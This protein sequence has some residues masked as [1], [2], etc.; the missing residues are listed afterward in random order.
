[1]AVNAEVQGLV[2][3]G[4]L[5]PMVDKGHVFGHHQRVHQ[6]EGILPGLGHALEDFMSL[7]TMWRFL[8][9]YR[10]ELLEPGECPGDGPACSRSWRRSA[11]GC[12]GGMR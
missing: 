3:G 11:R 1:M 10:P 12:G 8:E 7:T 6:H 2:R 4:A 5:R 9:L